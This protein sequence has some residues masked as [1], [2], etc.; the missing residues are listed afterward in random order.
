F[1]II[2]DCGPKHRQS[3]GVGELAMARSRGAR[4][5]AL[6]L[7]LPLRKPARSALPCS[8]DRQSG[9][10]HPGQLPKIRRRIVMSGGTMFDYDRLHT[11]VSKLRQKQIFFIGGTPKSASTWLQLLLNAH[12]SV[13]CSGEGH[14]PDRLW[15][16][17]KQAVGQHCQSIQEHNK[18]LFNGHSGY[19]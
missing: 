8:S 4:R 14:F 2:D 16:P 19:S 6:A 12:P 10:R 3:A 13:S 5:Q 15:G 7:A 17:L 11:A 9:T 1:D 18:K